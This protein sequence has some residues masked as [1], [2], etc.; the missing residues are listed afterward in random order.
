M[1]ICT[2]VG[3]YVYMYIRRYMLK[4]I[5]QRNLVSLNLFAI[6]KTAQIGHNL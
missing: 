3:I 6:G 5:I 4:F 1:Y 2:Y